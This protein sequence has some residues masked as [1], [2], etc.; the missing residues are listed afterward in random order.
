MITS[1]LPN[2]IVKFLATEV[3]LFSDLDEEDISCEVN[4]DV[5]EVKQGQILF[6]EGDE[7]ALSRCKENA[8]DCVLGYRS[9][10]K[11]DKRCSTG[12]LLDETLGSA[13][14]EALS[15]PKRFAG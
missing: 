1:K 5:V 12:L 9:R 2:D 3:E 8:A 7:R 10:Y 15:N 6:K 14:G 11:S 13:G 4:G